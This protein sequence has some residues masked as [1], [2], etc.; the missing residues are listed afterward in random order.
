MNTDIQNTSINTQNLAPIS[1]LKRKRRPHG[2][3]AELPKAI[4]DQINQMLDDGLSFRKIAEEL[5]ASNANL[6]EGSISKSGISRWH[7]NG[8]Q[9]HLELQER[10]TMVRANREASLDMVNDGDTTTLPEADLQLIAS[11]YY[12]IFAQNQA[13]IIK[14]KLAEDPLHYPRFLNAFA[15]LTREILKLKTYRELREKEK[16]AEL[17]RLDPNRKLNQNESAA[18]MKLWNDFFLGEDY[19]PMAHPL[20][21]PQPAASKAANGLSEQENRANTDSNQPTARPSA[22]GEAR[23]EGER[24]AL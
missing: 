18:L 14:Q 5:K 16:A 15:R 7:D 1:V 12:D 9:R 3:I 2:K 6:P 13:H 11:Q 10:L 21:D 23:S 4:R 8:Y 19:D 20:H 17:K 24:G 22:G